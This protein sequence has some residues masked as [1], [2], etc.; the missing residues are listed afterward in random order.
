MDFKLASGASLTV[1]QAPFVDAMALQKAL[2]ASVKGLPLS[3]DIMKM[4]VSVLKDGVIAAATSPEVEK[5][6]FQCA[7]RATYDNIVVSS[8]LFD[9]P[10]IGTQ[11]RKDFYDIAWKII[12]VNCGP[13]FKTT[14]SRLKAAL[15]AAPAASQK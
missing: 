5:A 6:L 12:E 7:A 13:F 10:K 2:L 4:D 3:A 1:S 15:P 14:F 8:D 9:D 11:A